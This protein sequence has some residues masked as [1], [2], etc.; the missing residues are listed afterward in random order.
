M[1]NVFFPN[2]LSTA[3]EERDVERSDDRVSQNHLL[4]NTYILTFYF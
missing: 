2:P 4:I 3:G 1:L